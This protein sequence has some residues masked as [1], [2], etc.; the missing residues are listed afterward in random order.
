MKALLVCF[1]IILSVLYVCADTIT[2]R[3]LNKNRMPLLSS[4]KIADS[5]MIDIDSVRTDILGNFK[6]VCDSNCYYINISA[7][8]YIPQIYSLSDIKIDSIYTFTLK[9]DTTIALNEVQIYADRKV[10][11]LEKTTLYP[12]QQILRSNHSVLGVLNDLMLPGLETNS[13]L[14]TASINGK[15]VIFKINGLN[16]P[17]E[18][19]LALSP[20]AILKIE[21]SNTPSI[22]EATSG[23]G[24]VINIIL[25]E[26]DYGLGLYNSCY[27]AVTAGMANE[28][29]GL[30]LV[31]GH[32]QLSI[33]YNVQW[34]SYQH[35]ETDSY[36]EYLCEPYL[37]T[38][39]VSSRSGQLK[40][41][42]N[43]L[44]VS[45]VYKRDNM[46]VLS[47]SFGY[48]FGPWKR[49]TV[50]DNHE[51]SFVDGCDVNY[52]AQKSISQPY[53]VPSMELTF[54]RK[55]NNRSQLEWNVSSGF[56]YSRNTWNQKYI[57]E[58]R[59][60]DIYNNDILSDKWSLMTDMT[61][62][63]QYGGS[64]LKLGLNESYT[65]SKNSYDS[66]DYY[67][68]DKMRENQLFPYAEFSSRIKMLSFSFGSGLYIVYRDNSNLVS[69]KII[70]NLSTI[71]LFLKPTH[72]FSMLG[73]VKFEP[74]YPALGAIADYVLTTDYITVSKGN[75]NLKSSSCLMSETTFSFSKGAFSSDLRG[76]YNKTWN[77]LF[78]TVSFRQ[79]YYV[80]STINGS[81]ETN[82]F[83]G[84]N[85]QFRKFVGDNYS[86][87]FKIS[88]DICGFSSKISELFQHDL[89]SYY[90]SGNL[91]ANF[92]N[93]TIAA[94]GK[95]QYKSLT[96]ELV[97]A[98]GPY[99]NISI[100]Y[101]WKSLFISIVGSWLGIKDGD[102]KKYKS[103]SSDNPTVN[104]NIIRDNAN[105]IGVGITYRLD[106]GKH[107][108]ATRERQ[109]Q[110]AIKQK[111][112][113]LIE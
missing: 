102:Y 106:R 78:S 108:I 43:D 19:V 44:Y 75:P 71:R 49:E 33:D 35:S 27:S 76:S 23:A 2:G 74:I 67:T 100:S 81:S 97:S 54:Q 31:K 109:K 61:W 6:I 25:K 113:Q 87:G 40:M 65:Y 107:A 57:Y 20:T 105:C 84:I 13:I 1:Y 110:S 12:E 18:S 37:L 16:K 56:N 64:S 50:S 3:V 45:Y 85:L 90:I 47:V 5:T 92:K 22:K 72:G 38:R 32:H 42:L 10:T 86:Y 51:L 9:E 4:V 68:R 36:S 34:R 55:F 112:V 21:Y 95:S 101:R 94:S 8:G 28:T 98:I 46:T 41:N 7:P 62:I 11:S 93:W 91:F 30:S 69:Q 111:S 96:G 104:K 89:L 82:Y 79:P 70:N 63:K 14:Q 52:I 39:K 103:L 77:P 58:N 60:D 80:T 83:I 48:L 26:S 99:T 53:S 24:G 66:H 88:T 73:T 59:E 15:S 29:L 17:I